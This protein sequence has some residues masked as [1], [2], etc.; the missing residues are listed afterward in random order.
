[1]SAA[2]LVELFTALPEEAV[3]GGPDV[4]CYEPLGELGPET[5]PQQRALGNKAR[6]RAAIHVFRKQVQARYTEGTLLRLLQGGD[7]PARRAAVFALGLIGSPAVNDALAWALHDE[8]AEVGELAA[9]ALWALWFRGP[10]SALSDE[11]YRALR[12]R[13]PD[14]ALAALTGLIAKA[15]KFAEALNQRAILHFR[16]GQFDRSA[17]DCEAVLKLN[18]HHFGAQ[19]GLGQCY[20]RLRRHRAAL[21]AFRTAVRINPRLDGVAQVVQ[22][23]EKALGDEGR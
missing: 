14:E 19:A 11:L 7:E 21:R 10:G 13:G 2:L 3:H 22:A 5:A 9:D 18:P 6:R 4:P 1:M 16:L 23:L 8:A 20:L 15:P 17:T 12:R